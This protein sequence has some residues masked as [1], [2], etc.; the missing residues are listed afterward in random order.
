M[1]LCV[2]HVPKKFPSSVFTDGVSGVLATV[3][4]GGDYLR[5]CTCLQCGQAGV[6]ST[7]LS[8]RTTRRKGPLS[9]IVGVGRVC[10]ASLTGMKERENLRLLVDPLGVSP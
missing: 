8:V 2:M 4:T 7:R 5:V 6:D 9:D 3:L 10:P 1:F